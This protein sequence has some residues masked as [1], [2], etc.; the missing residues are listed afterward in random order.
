[1][2]IR[3]RSKTLVGVGCLAGISAA[4]WAL[5]GSEALSM[6]NHPDQVRVW[7]EGL[8][9]IG[10][11]AII[12]TMALAIVVSP[13]PSAPIAL[14]AGALYGH[15]WGTIYI[16]IGA[17]S[18]ALIAFSIARIL[19]HDTINR[20]VGARP[21]LR[22][23]TSQNTLMAAVFGARLIPFLSF[24]IISYAAGL[25]P[26]RPW[27]FGLAT[28]VGIA[29]AS[30]TLAH[31]GGELGSGNLN[32]AAITIFGLGGFTFASIAAGWWWRRRT[33][34]RSGA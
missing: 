23:F 32:R 11:L 21:S 19:G 7:I 4:Y 5:A 12:A 31:F 14:A 24:D 15:G 34:M 29:P 22:A 13:L 18:G 10:P 3:I 30:F 1:M 25:S 27:R 16:I 9:A 20:W 33:S 17:E 6:L 2:A 28:L 8:G 26:L